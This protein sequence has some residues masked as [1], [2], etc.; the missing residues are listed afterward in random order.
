MQRLFFPFL[1][2]VL[3][4]WQAGAQISITYQDMPRSGD[5]IRYTN[6]NP[7]TQLDLNSSGPNHH[8]D[9]SG[10]TLITQGVA[11]FKKATQVSSTYGIYFGA[12][13]YG[14]KILDSIGYQ[15]YQIRDIYD[16]YSL[17]TNL[18]QAVG[19]GLTIPV[20]NFPVPSTYTTKDKIYQLPLTYG[21]NDTSDYAVAFSVLTYGSF[22]QKGTRINIVDG[23]GTITT[24]YNTYQCIRVKSI[25]N[26]RDSLSIS[27]IGNPVAFDNNMVQY[28]WLANGE[29]I[30]VL[31]VDGNMIG[32]TF[33]P[34]SVKYRD[35]YHDSPLAP[36]ADFTVN[37]QV[38]TTADTFHFTNQ[39]SG[40]G[41]SYQ[42]TFSPNTMAYV[43]S[44]SSTS[45][46]PNVQFTAPGL[47]TVQL[48][49]SNFVGG[50]TKIK[51][52]YVTVSQFNGIEE[53]NLA[54]DF[55][56]FYDAS[57]HQID[58]RFT[59][60]SAATVS[61]S[62]YGLEG[63]LERTLPETKLNSGNASQTLTTNGLSA[64]V[65]VLVLKVNDTYLTK[66]VMVQ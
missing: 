15:Q 55:T 17:S 50:T 54:G 64:G 32:G 12:N 52:E 26:E 35:S 20:V 16:F 34:T 2:I 65:Y 28:K 25:I 62:L 13:A 53:N 18:F 66:K 49:A 60:K 58:Y 30:P 6:A 5:T 10:L 4:A 27:Q 31:E 24:P 11:E 39:T 46:N 45:T 44:S 1:L 57:G 37:S 22:T 42:W 43:G 41:S 61:A 36:S 21:A 51:Q 19:R 9:Y 47:Y 23:W 38:G 7:A 40:I 63:R 29:K 59:L 33:V 3:T 48:Y 56:A 8:W 14:Q